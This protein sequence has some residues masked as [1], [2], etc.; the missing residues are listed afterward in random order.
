MAQR[1]TL[2]AAHPSPAA[3]PPLAHASE[4]RRGGVLGSRP[5]PRVRGNGFRRLLSRT[6]E[7]R[8]SSCMQ[9]SLRPLR[10]C[11]TNVQQQTIGEQAEQCDG[12]QSE[13]V[14]QQTQQLPSP[15][16]TAPARDLR[17][18]WRA[19]PRS[20]WRGWSACSGGAAAA[21]SAACPPAQCTA[22]DSCG[23]CESA[24]NTQIGGKIR[25]ERRTAA[26]SCV[27]CL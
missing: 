11:S 20:C 15:S 17:W 19:S 8:D 4:R 23:T 10:L 18:P 27:R 5:F 7:R 13:C 26:P 6:C 9:R 12:K 21:A 16:I 3:A 2:T 22:A 24:F 14:Q 1:S 25:G